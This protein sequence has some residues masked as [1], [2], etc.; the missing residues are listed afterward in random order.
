MT[1]AWGWLMAEARIPGVRPWLGETELDMW[2]YRDRTV[3]LLKRYA[4][5]SVEVGRLPSL[6]GRECFRARVSS[7]PM[8][9]FEDIV[10][11][12]HDMD[13]ALGRLNPFQQRLIAMNVLEEY[14]LP[15]VARLLPCPLRT[16][17]REVPDAL[18]VLS[19][20]FLESGLIKQ[21]G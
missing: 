21:A 10:I 9:S 18:D 8:T 7:Y 14:S 2:P 1:A 4:R 15:E 11:F 20:A 19:R 16:V 13:T 5:A 12:V 3:A 17:E 6:L